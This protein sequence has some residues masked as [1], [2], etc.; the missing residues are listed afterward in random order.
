MRFEC[1]TLD[2]EPLLVGFEEI[3][4]AKVAL[5]SSKICQNVRLIYLENGY[6]ERKMRD[7]NLALEEV[8][9]RK[10][11]LNLVGERLIR[12]A[13]NK[14]YVVSVEIIEKGRDI[15]CFKAQLLF[16]LYCVL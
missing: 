15:D 13:R 6:S 10:Y 12:R 11:P 8:Q 7:L 3:D 5:F 16:V 1:K 14:I 4:A 2:A 9:R